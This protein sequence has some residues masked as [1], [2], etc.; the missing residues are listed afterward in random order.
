M[1]RNVE[2]LSR[3]HR[4]RCLVLRQLGDLI[5]W[6]LPACYFVPQQKPLDRSRDG[7]ISLNIHEIELWRL[8]DGSWENLNDILLS[9]VENVNTSNLINGVF[10]FLLS[11]QNFFDFLALARR[12]KIWC[13]KKLKLTKSC[14]T[15]FNHHWEVT[16]STEIIS[17]AAHLLDRSAVLKWIGV[18]T[19]GKGVQA[20]MCR[21]CVGGTWA[22]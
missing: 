22:Q 9:P 1:V 7:L 4:H 12:D 10:W 16:V 13:S 15:S 11:M 18:S 8:Q 5:A 17:L 2:D 14:L 20:K 3:C 19:E 21:C 6:L